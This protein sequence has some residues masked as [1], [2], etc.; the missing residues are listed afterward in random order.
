[1]ST[2]IDTKYIRLLSP[3]LRNFKQKGANLF[4]F[5][6]PI[7]GDSQRNKSKARGYTFEKSGGLFYKCHNCGVGTNVGNLI[8]STDQSLYNEY[9]LERYKAGESGNSNY[10]KP[11]FNIPQPR[12][13]KIERQ[14]EFQHAEWVSDLPS[15]HF[16]LEYATKRQI[17]LKFYD[18]LLFTQH[19]N[20]F[21]TTLIPNHGKTITDDARLVI[22]FYDEYNEL[23]AISGRALQTND[24]TLRY[25]TLRTRET[26]EK[27]VYGLERVDLSK[28]VKVVEGP[29]DSLFLDNCVASGDANLLSVAKKI[30]SDK[31]IL[32]FDNEKRNKEI[33]KMMQDA[34]NSQQDV[35]I[36]PDN[37]V[38]KDINEMVMNGLSP[39]EIESIISSNT[40]SGLKA[41][42]R[43][44]FW[45]RV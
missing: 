32:I 7:C 40:L 43:F 44:T 38:G 28:P 3:R 10:K 23:I 2:H 9:I 36:W 24:K 12:F 25:I 35:V 27:L 34:I 26:E 4:N 1:M 13:D 5:S 16:C 20:Q 31:I 39:S 41:Q 19:Y 42:T 8:K 6:C 18:K 11:T 15:G 29:I 30:K 21:V 37:I 14:K 17:P 33:L 22:P 45:K